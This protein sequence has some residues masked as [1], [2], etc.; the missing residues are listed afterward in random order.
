MSREELE[1]EEEEEEEE[2]LRHEE[3]LEPPAVF[4]YLPSR[5][6]APHGHQTV[7]AISGSNVYRALSEVGPWAA[8][9]VARISS[10]SSPSPELWYQTHGTLVL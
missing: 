5:L 1:E 9:N 10:S 8:D 4:W 6:R 3:V 7:T 2:T